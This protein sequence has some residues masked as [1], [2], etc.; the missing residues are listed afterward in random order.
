M[1]E[2]SWKQEAE[3]F[4][5]DSALGDSEY[6]SIERTSQE[7]K[8]EDEKADG[9]DSDSSERTSIFSEIM[10]YREENGRRYH[11]YKDGSYLLVSLGRLLTPK[12]RKSREID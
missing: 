4:E 12:E 9:V 6:V 2:G 7:L 3:N 10:R 1:I 5:I 8:Q 11:G